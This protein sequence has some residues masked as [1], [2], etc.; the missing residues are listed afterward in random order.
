MVHIGLLDIKDISQAQVR[1]LDGEI[2]GEELA[3]GRLVMQRG[4]TDILSKILGYGHFIVRLSVF[5]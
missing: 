4:E 1:L 5:R 3:D 2:E